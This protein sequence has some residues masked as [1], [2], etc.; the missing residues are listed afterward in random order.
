MRYRIILMILPCLFSAQ[1][2][3]QTKQEKIDKGYAY[4]DTTF[5]ELAKSINNGRQ[6]GTPQKVMEL[7]IKDLGS[8]A[9]ALVKF[10]YKVPIG[11]TEENRKENVERHSE[12]ARL[13]CRNSILKKLK[14]SK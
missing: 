3:A 1:I 8:D 10:A 9:N 4:C 11:K 12:A 5:Y 14:N 2:F 13:G 6:S 7:M